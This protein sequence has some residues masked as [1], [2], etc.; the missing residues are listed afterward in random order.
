L[1]ASWNTNGDSK[2]LVWIA[3]YKVITVKQLSVL[4]FRSPQVVRRRLRVF[5]DKEIV[6]TR[7]RGYGKNRGRPENIVFLTEKG[8]K[9][10]LNKGLISEHAACTIG[11]TLEGFSVNHDLLVNWFRIHL[12]QIER[13]IPMLSVQNLSSVLF[14][15]NQDGN[16]A[17]VD[18]KRIRVTTDSTKSVEFIPDEVFLIRQEKVKNSLLFFLEVDMGTETIASLDRKSGDLR[19]KILNYQALFESGYYKHYEDVFDSRLNG[20]RLLFLTDTF[21]RLKAISRLVQDM[22]P[23]DFIW[24][25]DRRDMFAHG[26]SANIW[27]RGG[28][29]DNPPQSIL[30]QNF[31]CET[32]LDKTISR[33][34]SISKDSASLTSK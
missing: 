7:E 33:T 13:S 12:L 9:F 16:D 32:P 24:V 30:G 19:Q 28:K 25:A 23:S 27:A 26:L 3:R 15:M 29:V 6:A 1:T 2:L 18:Q 17:S 8:K 4:T 31:V 11:S 14:S 5:E 21:A 20:F 22:P 34:P 10:L